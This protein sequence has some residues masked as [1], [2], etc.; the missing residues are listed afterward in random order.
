MFIAC[1]GSGTELTKKRMD[2]TFSGKPVSDIVVIVVADEEKTR[3]LF[4]QKFVARLKHAGVDADSSIEA[5]SMPSNLKLKK[6]AILKAV[7]HMW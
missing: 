7:E 2:N 6:E 1:A 3:R 5:I 4:E